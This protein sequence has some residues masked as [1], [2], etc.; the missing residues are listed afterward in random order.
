MSISQRA[1]VSPARVLL[2][3]L[4]MV[5]VS[6]CASYPNSSAQQEAQYVLNNDPATLLQNDNLNG[7][8]TQAPA[9]AVLNVPKSP[10]GNNVEVVA[11]DAYL[12]A[13][14]RECRKLTVVAVDANNA[15][16]ALV[17]KTPNGWVNQRVVTQTTQG[18]Y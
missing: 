17:C 13:S 12:A 14:G 15:R 3:A 10:W 4:S 7:F 18:R 16:S 2:A 1:V 5:V 8:L 6:G 11:D 9:G